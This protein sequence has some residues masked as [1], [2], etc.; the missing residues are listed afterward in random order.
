MQSH[1]E[2]SKIDQEGLDI[3]E[4]P[5]FDGE[6]IDSSLVMVTVPRDTSA[7][8]LPDDGFVVISPLVA[9]TKK[10]KSSETNQGSLF[11]EL[12]R[13][14]QNRHDKGVFESTTST[15]RQV[16]VK[17]VETVKKEG[18]WK[19]ADETVKRPKSEVARFTQ[20][21]L[22]KHAAKTSLAMS[23]ALQNKIISYKKNLEQ[24]RLDFEASK[25]ITEPVEYLKTVLQLKINHTLLLCHLI[26]LGYNGLPLSKTEQFEGHE[27]RAINRVLT[28]LITCKQEEF[29]QNLEKISVMLAESLVESDTVKKED[30]TTIASAD[31]AISQH[32]MKLRN[33]L[34]RNNYILPEKTH[35][36]H[37]LLNLVNNLCE[38]MTGKQVSAIKLKHFKDAVHQTYTP[39]EWQKI[40]LDELEGYKPEGMCVIL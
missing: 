22:A 12:L 13:R 1:M 32:F 30:I 31:N 24:I 14:T 8:P 3:P 37:Y 15:T 6:L 19:I 27:A 16:Q 11:E 36:A 17:L 33:L 4:A 35:G 7:S 18:K 29:C 10:P 21:M 28:H 5:P 26:S 23:E 38:R 39:G 20:E 25:K 34:V 40:T 2:A 9:Q